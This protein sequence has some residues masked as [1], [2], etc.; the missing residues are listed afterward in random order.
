MPKTSTIPPLKERIRLAL[1]FGPR[2][3]HYVLHAVFPESH[4]PRAFKV[5]TK[6]GPPGCA[7]AFGRALRE[8]GVTEYTGGRRGRGTLSR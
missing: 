2:S 7:F 5:A 3:Y 6:G 8:M 4:F 1:K